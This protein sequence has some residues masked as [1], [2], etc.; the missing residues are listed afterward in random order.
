MVKYFILSIFFFISACL[1]T[2]TKIFFGIY[3]MVIGM[4]IFHKI[5]SRGEQ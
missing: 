4:N 5:E 3:T 1:V 2:D